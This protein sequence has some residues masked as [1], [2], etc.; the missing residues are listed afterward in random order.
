MIDYYLNKKCPLISPVGRQLENNRCNGC[1]W[2]DKRIQPHK[3]IFS[4]DYP[5]HLSVTLADFV[6]RMEKV[7]KKQQSNLSNP[8]MRFVLEGKG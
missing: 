2:L 4:L 8:T 6:R 1:V 5:A 3:C 7:N